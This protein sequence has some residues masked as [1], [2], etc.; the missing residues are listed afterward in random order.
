MA[1][2][3]VKL[4]T[5]PSEAPAVAATDPAR[6]TET[7]G[8]HQPSP[9]PAALRGTWK[10]RP[11]PDLSIELTVREDGQFTWDINTNG[12]AE[13]IAGAADYA[14]GVLTLTQDDAPALVG[15]VVNLGE[16][17]FGFELVG[18]PQSATVQFSR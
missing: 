9:P 6:A 2:Q 4:L 5:P 10:A 13:S 12:Q 15:K 14:D 8:M 3:F 11:T 1:A 18:G 16:K 7:A 17:Q